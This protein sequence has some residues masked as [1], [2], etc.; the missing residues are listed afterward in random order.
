MFMFFFF[1]GRH[2]V[3]DFDSLL[4]TTGVL[5]KTHRCLDG[6]LNFSYLA[7]ACSL[8]RLAPVGTAT[9]V[10]LAAFRTPCRISTMAP[11]I[12]ADANNTRL[13][14]CSEA[15]SHPR[16]IATTGLPYAC[17]ATHVG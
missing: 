9:G 4:C 12:A 7:S 6:F 8:P 3:P 11:R 17:V 2:C 10:G 5:A 15:N 14:T 1:S 16:K 13:P